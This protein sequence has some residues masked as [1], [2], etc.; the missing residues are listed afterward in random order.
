MKIGQVVESGDVIGT[1][2]NS[3]FSSGPHLRFEVHL[4]V[5]EENSYGGAVDPLPLL[6]EAEMTLPA[7]LFFPSSAQMAVSTALNLRLRPSFD[8]SLRGCLRKGDVVIL[9]GPQ[10]VTES[11]FSF[12][13]VVLWVAKEYLQTI[14]GAESEIGQKYEDFHIFHDLSTVFPRLSTGFNCFG[15]PV[16]WGFPRKMLVFPYK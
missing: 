7:N 3:G 5:C 11:G 13:P 14:E 15:L 12:V 16:R 2:G 1:S 8:N 6:E 10:Q 9:A 4:P